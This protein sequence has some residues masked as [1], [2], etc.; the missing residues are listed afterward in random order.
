M[1]LNIR[2][3][4]DS[5]L[6]RMVMNTQRK[7]IFLCMLGILIITCA[8][9][10]QSQETDAGN[11]NTD[12]ATG[13]DGDADGDTDADV[14]SDSGIDAGPY[15]DLESGELIWAV[16]IGGPDND[17]GY[18]IDTLSDGSILVT[19]YYMETAIFGKG[20]PN[21]TILVSTDEVGNFFAKYTSKGYLAWA[22]NTGGGG[23]GVSG[24][25]DG[26]L[27]ITGSFHGTAIFGEGDLNEIS[28][29]S[30]GSSDMYIARYNSDGSMAWAKNAESD[31]YVFASGH[32]ITTIKNC[33]SIVTGAF[34]ESIVFGRG[35]ENETSFTSAGKEDIF[36]AQ[37]RPDGRLVWALS[38]GGSYGD[39]GRGIDANDDNGSFVITGV[40]DGVIIAS[41]DSEGIL[42]WERRG[43]GSRTSGGADVAV[44]NDKSVI[45]TGSFLESITFDDGDNGM[46]PLYGTG[47]GDTDIFIVK[48][49]KDGILEWAK[50]AGGPNND[51]VTGDQGKGVAAFPDGSSVVTGYFY[52]QA[53]FGKGDTNEIILEGSGGSLDQSFFLVKYN[54]DGTLDWAKAVDEAQHG[55]CVAVN[56]DNSIVVSGTFFDTVTF[57]RGEPHET[58]LQ[59]EGSLDIF[60]AKFAP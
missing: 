6:L 30:S 46:R 60:I 7:N 31:A 39:S 37:Y 1:I 16:S 25:L 50:S 27:L 57:G 44:C 53:T 13:S 40:Y 14:D 3:V 29:T 42:Q 9:S 58:V 28:L 8:C 18:N 11:Q 23:A 15:A 48:Y 32:E 52:G 35:E 49:N 20:D 41:Y 56:E 55:M 45:V 54:S 59:S 26:S 43:T 34:K 12:A 24:C 10:D 38:Y 21:Q 51:D 4:T 19:G 47:T 22:K 33:S 5:L 2:N 17:I 36:I